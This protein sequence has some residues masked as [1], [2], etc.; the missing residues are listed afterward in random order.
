MSFRIPSPARRIGA[1][2]AALALL[3]VLA[4]CQ[5]V[6]IDKYA[7]GSPDQRLAYALE[8]L[9]AAR[10]VGR[11]NNTIMDEERVIVDPETVKVEIE[12]LAFEFP[13]H[14]P[15]L[16]TNAELAF[17]ASEYEKS[18]AY[19]DRI[20]RM[21][22]DNV[23]AGIIRARIALV[24]GNV[25]YARRVLQRQLEYAPESPFIYEVLAGVEFLDGRFAESAKALD[26]AEALGGEAWRIAYHRGLIS[27][28]L[29]QREDAARHFRGCLEIKPQYERARAHLALL[30][31]GPTPVN[32]GPTMIAPLRR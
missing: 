9:D 27:E 18:Q 22:P 21:Q 12:T 17:E 8:R 3:V 24:D 15:I 16:L 11:N 2:M 32:A 20:L 19:C 30:E 10:A 26:H 25:P 5:H 6:P 7:T 13:R 14:V 1:A 28:R 29:G 4:A 23:F 31:H